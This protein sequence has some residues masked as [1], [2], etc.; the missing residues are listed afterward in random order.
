[1]GHSVE[2]LG[3]VHDNHVWLLS[4]LPVVNDLIHDAQQLADT[5]CLL[6]GPVLLSADDLI[7]LR[8]CHGDMDDAILQKLVRYVP[9]RDKTLVFLTVTFTLL[10]NDDTFAF[11]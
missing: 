11:F 8:K 6:S 1:M 2:G 9:Q 4:F 5:G 3:E 10:N 7:F